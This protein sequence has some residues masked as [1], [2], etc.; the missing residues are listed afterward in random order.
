MTHLNVFKGQANQI[1]V[2]TAVPT[3]REDPMY[4]VGTDDGLDDGELFYI[5]GE[6]AIAVNVSGTWRF[7]QLS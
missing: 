6:E 1:E 3:T 7:V 2:G 5:S 4:I